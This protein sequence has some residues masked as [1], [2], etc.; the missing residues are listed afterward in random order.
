LPS[1]VGPASPQ[2]RIL[3]GSPDSTTVPSSPARQTMMFSS[4]E[5]SVPVLERSDTVSSI[6]SL[7]REGFAASR[8]P[9]PRTPVAVNSSKSLDRGLPYRDETL[10]SYSRRQPSVVTEEDCEDTGSPASPHSYPP[11][12]STS[13]PAVIV[14]S[15]TVAATIPPVII[16]PQTMQ[17]PAKYTPLPTFVLP[18]L[19]SDVNLTNQIFSDGLLATPA[20]LTSTA[21]TESERRAAEIAGSIQCAECFQPIVGRIVNAMNRRFHPQCFAC[22]ECGDLLEHVSSY[23]W[24]G[25]AYC[26]LDYHDVRQFRIEA[27]RQKFAHHCFYCKTAIVDDRFITLNDP[28][29][30]ERYYHEL[31]FFCSECGDPFLDP[32]RSSAPGNK[33][34]QQDDEGETNPFVIHKGHP[35]CERCHMR[36]HKPKCKACKQPIPDFA[37]DALGSKWHKDCFLCSVGIS[38]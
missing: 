28:S 34:L 20:Q 15:V 32:S 22:N 7:D 31:H 38:P 11:S 3:P 24:G 13:P 37:I 27:N 23:E 26:H 6:K 5:A 33:L 14:P 12:F 2:T 36:L 21:A 9:L 16:E 1:P 30:G 8:R 19:D 4:K 18:A 17:S 35:Y 29:L 25:R 10:S